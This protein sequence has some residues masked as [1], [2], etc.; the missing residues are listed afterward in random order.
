MYCLECNERIIGRVDKKFCDELC[1]NR[2]HNKINCE[3]ARI[4]RQI[5]TALKRN[6]RII[7]E[8]I[9]EGKRTAR[10]SWLARKGFDFELVTGVKYRRSGAPCFYCYDY[11]Y[12]EL[13]DQRFKLLQIQDNGS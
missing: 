1:R 7:S 11:G 12:I 10:R 6:R 9:E 4:M 8:L 13:D 2:Y 5:N 3:E